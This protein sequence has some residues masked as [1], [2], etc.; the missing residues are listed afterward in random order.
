M[1]T[2]PQAGWAKW[3]CNKCGQIVDR[4]LGWRT[5]IPS[6]CLETGDFGRLYRISAPTKK[7]TKKKT[8]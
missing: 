3:K 4:D 6:L 1:N 2:K 8:Q 5:W 7:S